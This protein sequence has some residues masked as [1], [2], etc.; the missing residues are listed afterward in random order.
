MEKSLAFYPKCCRGTD[1]LGIESIL[2]AIVSKC[3]LLCS[4][5]DLSPILYGL[6]FQSLR[7]FFFTE[8]LINA[9]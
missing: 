2:R 6:Y 4:L 7:S 3:I 9:H 1:I 8:M 5:L